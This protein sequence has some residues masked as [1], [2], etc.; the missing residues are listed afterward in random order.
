MAIRERPALSRRWGRITY[1]L[2]S[3]IIVDDAIVVIVKQEEHTVDVAVTTCSE[4]CSPIGCDRD[5]EVGPV[6]LQ[7]QIRA[8]CQ[9]AVG[10]GPV[11]AEM[12]RVRPLRRLRCSVNT[13][14]GT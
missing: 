10:P 4:V 12:S 1:D 13:D 8:A 6:V 9:A 11:E 5:E 2:L 7:P 3:V 14:I